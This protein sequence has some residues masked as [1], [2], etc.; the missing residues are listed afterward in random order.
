VNSQKTKKPGLFVRSVSGHT[1]QPDCFSKM[2]IV[3]ETYPEGWKRTPPSKRSDGVR[4]VQVGVFWNA[5][6][7]D[8]PRLLPIF[9]LGRRFGDCR[10][11]GSAGMDF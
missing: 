4:Q 7:L 2:V 11:H 3:C 1:T 6:F 10:P 8:F 5:V 9:F